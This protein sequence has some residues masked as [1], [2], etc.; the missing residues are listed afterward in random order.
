[1]ED[2]RRFLPGRVVAM[3]GGGASPPLRVKIK[4]RAHHSAQKTKKTHKY[5]AEF[6]HYLSDYGKHTEFLLFSTQYSNFTTQ[7]PGMHGDVTELMC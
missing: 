2:P 3:V 1:M 7:H 6:T 5:L 4:A